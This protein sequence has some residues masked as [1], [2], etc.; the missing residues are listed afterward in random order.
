MNN[1]LTKTEDYRVLI[2]EL[3][4][5]VQSAQIKAALK[6]NEALIQLYWEIG[7]RIT[8]Q[9]Q[10]SAWGDKVIGQ[11]AT[12]LTRELGGIKGFSRRN[13]FYMQRLY[14][15][16][17][18]QPEIVQQLVA[19][20]PWGHNILIL[21]KI[22]DNQQALWYVQK[23]LQHGWSRNVLALQIDSQLYQRQEKTSKLDNFQDKLP[24]PD[25]DL[26]RES[27]KDPYVFDFLSVGDEAHERAIEQ[28]LVDQVSQFMLELG[29]GFAFVGKQFH[30]D[31]GGDDFYIDLLMYHL[32]LHCYVVIELKNGKFKPEYA[33]KLN[34]YLTAIDRQVKTP[35]DKLSIGLI[36]C[37][38]K[39]QIVAEYALHGMSQP[40]SISEFQLTKTLPEAL[41][42]SLPT[43]EEFET[44]LDQPESSRDDSAD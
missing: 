13:L 21:D 41:K 35:D 32:K 23:T 1:T 9:Q 6:V 39:N 11:I 33:G 5:K 19:Q 22:K 34:F 27:L 30:L 24:A 26:F 2:L 40:M 3:K 18:A 14:Q 28:A 8:E 12:D 16:Y 4:G 20:I 44:V 17:A 15:F 37:R 29:K 38:D 31:V 25:T 7:Q 43:L 10:V 42:D 36:L